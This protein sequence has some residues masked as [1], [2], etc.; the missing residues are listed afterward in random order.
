M[1]TKRLPYFELDIQRARDLIGLGQAVGSLTVGT[2][3][4]SDMFRAGLVQAVA[5]M[6]HYFHGV[7]LD[8][9]VDI[10]LGHT[11]I[12][13]RHR[14][15]GLQ[16]DA[17]RDILTAPTLTDREL[18]IRKHVAVQLAKETFQAADEIGAGLALVGVPKIWTIAFPGNAPAMQTALGVVVTRRNRIVHQA[19]GDPLN[20][21]H[22]TP[23]TSSDALDAI[24]AVEGTVL[25][26]DPHC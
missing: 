23:L 3:D 10:L 6:D 17:V 11:S 15:I 2:V 12:S 4:S 24:S 22:V 16:L 5:A 13:G 8:R 7:I 19:D 26:I 25:T 9:A 20:P 1:P 14:R 18:G 21:G